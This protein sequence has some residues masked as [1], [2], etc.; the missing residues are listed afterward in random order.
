MNKT[1]A[2]YELKLMEDKLLELLDLEKQTYRQGKDLYKFGKDIKSLN[3]EILEVHKDILKN[4]H[5]DIVELSVKQSLI[6]NL[7]CNVLM[8]PDDVDIDIDG[9]NI[10][11]N[12]VFS[13]DN[14]NKIINKVS[15]EFGGY[16]KYDSKE[17]LESILDKSN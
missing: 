7:R 5:S 3:K 4:M 14:V 15:A 6:R 2:L 10:I 1:E 11:I 9:Y 12:N 16:Y 17:V 8:L 13:V